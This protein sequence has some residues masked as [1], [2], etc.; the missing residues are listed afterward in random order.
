MPSNTSKKSGILNKLDTAILLKQLHFNDFQY[1]S[2]VLSHTNHRLNI[3]LQFSGN[4]QRVLDLGCGIGY[5]MEMLQTKHSKVFGV[6]IS[7]KALL[8]A[9]RK[10]L[11]VIQS[12]FESKLPFDDNQF[13]VVTAGEIIEHLYNTSLF[14]AEIRRILKK[15]GTLIMSTPNVASL[16]RRLMLLFGVSPFLETELS[17]TDAGHVRYFTKKSLLSLLTKNKFKPVRHTSDS[18]NFNN[19]LDSKLRSKTLA[20]VFPTLGAS[21]IVACINQK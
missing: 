21:I 10:G 3:M 19:K 18:I 20:K 8:T 5:F 13:D 11:N 17:K 16:G 2:S 6:D 7:K 4:N 1:Q 14:L 9:K 12:N 15:N